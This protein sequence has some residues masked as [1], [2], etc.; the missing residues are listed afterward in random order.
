[1]KLEINNL[2]IGYK[3]HPPL[4]SDINFS[5]ESGTSVALIGDNGSGKSTLLRTI[6][7]LHPHLGGDILLN[8]EDISRMN[9][10]HR[11]T[12]LSFV[13]TEPIMGGYTTVEQVVSLGRVP[14]SGWAGRLSD[15]DRSI[16]ESAMIETNTLEFA[17]RSINTLSDG[18]RQRVMI[19]RALCQSTPVL[20][21]DEPTAFLDPKNRS[22]VIDLLNRLAVEQGKIVIYSTHEVDLARISGSVLWHLENSHLNICT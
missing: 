14:Y 19:A 21:L 15:A 1:M 17:D 9:L 18:Q 4:C 11:S 2:S 13:S 22:G 5:V 20:V 3:G 8:G 6:A 7:S 16:V 10:S 12:C